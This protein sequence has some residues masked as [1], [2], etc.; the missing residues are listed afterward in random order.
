MF[1]TLDN[2]VLDRIQICQLLEVRQAIIIA[3][4]YQSV[5]SRASCALCE[6][7]HDLCAVRDRDAR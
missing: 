4:G 7:A 3:L 5:A 1:L 6:E 2:L